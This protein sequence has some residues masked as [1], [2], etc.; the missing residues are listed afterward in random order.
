MLVSIQKVFYFFSFI[1]IVLLIRTCHRL[2]VFNFA[3]PPQKKKILCTPLILKLILSSQAHKLQKTMEFA[4]DSCFED[5]TSKME[6]FIGDL[7][8]KHF[9]LSS[10]TSKTYCLFIRRCKA[11]VKWFQLPLLQR[12]NCF[13][14]CLIVH[15]H[16][17]V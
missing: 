13:I 8:M 11:R 3:P 1:Y 16:I 17:A 10:V 15:F 9:H 12:K 6:V 2:R 4:A 14:N 5:S 7:P